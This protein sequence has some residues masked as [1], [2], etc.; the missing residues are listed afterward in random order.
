MK[1][2]VISLLVSGILLAANASENGEAKTS[3]ET[4]KKHES[5]AS[6]SYVGNNG[7]KFWGTINSSFQT[8]ENGERQ[9]PINIAK[10]ATVATNSLGNLFFD[11][12]DTDISIVNNGHTIQVNSDNQSSALFQGKKFKLLQFHF[13]SK[14]EHTVN[15]EYYPLELHLVHQAED[16]EL[17]VVGV[18]FKLGDYNSSLQKVLKFMPKDAGAKN[19][20]DKFSINPNDFL[21][22]D[23][24]YY[25]YLGSLTTP[26]CTQIVEWYVMKNP[27]TL[28]QKQLEQFQN[29]YNGNFRPTYPLNKRIVLEK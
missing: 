6:W 1:K 16:G 25:H 17:G 4:H 14:S 23:R 13:H 29:L 8:C 2:Y 7:P 11:Y 10:E 20:S 24:G 26:P 9:S 22:K 15:G 12:K 3:S 19:A 28:S 27:I 18:F 5:H 21:P